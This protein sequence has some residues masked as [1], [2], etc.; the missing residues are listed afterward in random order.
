MEGYF[1]KNDH[2]LSAHEK[3]QIGIWAIEFRAEKPQMYVDPIMRDLLQIEETSPEEYYYDWYGRIFFDHTNMITNALE[4]MIAGNPAEIVFLWMHPKD[5]IQYVRLGGERDDSFLEGV[6]IYGYYQNMTR[7]VLAEKEKENL[8]KIYY[9]I[10]NTLGN[11]YQGI[12]MIHTKTDTV[13][14]IR[15]SISKEKQGKKMS[16]EQYFMMLQRWLSIENIAEMKRSIAAKKN[17]KDEKTF[18]SKDYSQMINDKMFWCN[19]TMYNEQI[20]MEHYIVVAFRDISKRK[21]KEQNDQAIIAYFKAQ[22]E[23]DGLTGL[24]N[25]KTFEQAV[26]AYLHKLETDEICAFMLLDLDYFKNVND[27]FGH[28][29]GDMLLIEVAEILRHKCRGEDIIARLGGDEFVIFLKNIKTQ[30]NAEAL[31][32]RIIQK[33]QKCFETEDGGKINVSASVGIA[34]APKTGRDFTTLYNHADEA[35]YCSKKNGKGRYTIF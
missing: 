35:L 17:C 12:H 20:E 5:G 13:T 16:L 1:R 34:L 11:M 8:E 33:L 26:N 30:E 22:S 24:K 19:V 32:R 3:M 15:T 7:C 29:K 14:L 28:I 6:R 21:Q 9:H 27:C 31:A 18:L 2:L 25:R 23:T 10:I 4:E